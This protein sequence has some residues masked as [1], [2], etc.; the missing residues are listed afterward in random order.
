MQY[1]LTKVWTEWKVSFCML[2][3][4]NGK[5]YPQAV[6][7]SVHVHKRCLFTPQNLIGPDEGTVFSLPGLEFLPTSFQRRLGG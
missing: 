6:C 4:V 7:G 1:L 5:I 2:R 3:K